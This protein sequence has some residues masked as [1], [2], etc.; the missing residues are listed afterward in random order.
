VKRVAPGSV[1][2]VDP[3]GA[4]EIPAASLAPRVDL[5]SGSPQ[6]CEAVFRDTLDRCTRDRV[7]IASGACVALSGGIDSATVA[8]SMARGAR[9]VHALSI[10]GAE[11][12]V[13]RL[14]IQALL[15][16]Y[17]SI[18]WRPIDVAEAAAVDVAELPL[19]DDP[20]AI[21][22]SFD[23]ARHVIFRAAREAGFARVLDGEGGDEVF[24]ENARFA[25]LLAAKDV[26]GIS[27]AIVRMPRAR[28]VEGLWPLLP[29]IAWRFHATRAA[30]RSRWLTGDFFRSPE[31]RAARDA[32]IGWHRELRYDARIRSLVH[33]PM[34]VGTGRYAAL[35]AD[36]NGVDASSPLLDRRMLELAMALPARVRFD[37]RESKAFLRAA[38]RDILPG[39]LVAH[40]KLA[41]IAE[42]LMDASLAASGWIDRALVE[43]RDHPLLSGAVDVDRF[44]AALAA[45]RSAR[46]RARSGADSSP[47][48]GAVLM[49]DLLRCALWLSR[50][51]EITAGTD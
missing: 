9:K 18:A 30:S 20:T 14:L 16:R 15:T 34:L 21:G 41:V 17:P 38:A 3:K 10:V 42:A 46:A 49:L 12:R 8:A 19:A 23:G 40:G 13:E 26:H 4:R 45:E 36:A 7:A 35:L 39:P 43:L 27:A 32:L 11:G 1:L 31:A 44:A 5:A 47:R 48:S 6:A 2:C 28:I 22:L 33:G 29:A 50:V 37:G 24:E 51:R 25:D